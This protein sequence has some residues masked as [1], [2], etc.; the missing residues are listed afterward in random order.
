MSEVTAKATR[1]GDH[2]LVHVPEVDRWTQ[3]RSLA[4]I[5]PMARDLAAIITGEAADAIRVVVEV[6]LPTSVRAHLEEVERAR[7]SEAAARTRGAAELRRAVRELRDARIS[8]REIGKLLGISHQRV[9]QL[10]GPASATAEADR[11]LAG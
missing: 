11:R 8:L 1:D 3:A 9:S 6:E 10:A 7:E 4:E 5:E 2:W